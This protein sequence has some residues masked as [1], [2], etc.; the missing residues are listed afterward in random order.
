MATGPCELWVTVE[1]VAECC[2][3]GESSS[4]LE[5]AVLAAVQSL[6]KLGGKQHSGRCQRP[7]RPPGSHRCLGPWNFWDGSAWAGQGCRA[8]SRIRLAGHATDIVEVTIDGDVID[9][10]TYELRENRWL[11]RMRDPAD[12]DTPLYWPSCQ[13]MDIDAGEEGTFEIVYGYGVDPPESGRL[14]A[15]EL[16]C[17]IFANACGS[18]AGA[19]GV[20]ELPS[21]VV[22]VER[23]GITIELSALSKWGQDADGTWITGMPMVDLYLNAENPTGKRKRSRVWSPDYPRFP[24][25]VNAGS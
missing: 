15:R 7:V 8:L 4:L 16:A 17:S 14:A 25:P 20:C 6:Y 9:P 23:E 3:P 2:E 12:L 21:G 1:E 11:V 10:Q 24:R 18:G 13:N 22:R 19:E 5:S